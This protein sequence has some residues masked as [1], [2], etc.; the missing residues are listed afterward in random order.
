MIRWGATTLD[1]VISF[2]EKRPIGAPIKFWVQRAH[3]TLTFSVRRPVIFLAAVLARWVTLIMMVIPIL[4]WV[5][6][7]M[8]TQA[9]TA[10]R[11]TYFLVAVHFR[12]VALQQ[13]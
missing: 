4:P 9:L 11:C 2:W 1:S 13:H 10:G 8:M 5:P 3:S 7:P 6:R 12:G